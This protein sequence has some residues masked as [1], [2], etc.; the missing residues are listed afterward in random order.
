MLL[1]LLLFFCSCSCSC[2]SCSCSC[3][4]CF[5]CWLL[6]VGGT[7][8]FS[9]LILLQ[10]ALVLIFLWELGRLSASSSALA[11][12]PI[13]WGHRP[14]AIQSSPSLLIGGFHAYRAYGFFMIFIPMQPW[15]FRLGILPQQ[16]NHVILVVKPRLRHQHLQYLLPLRRHQG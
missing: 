12:T 13:F 2:F 4:S 7:Y 15:R 3:F 11:K 5:S 8:Q 10:P 1:L 16:T 6:V 9:N 14:L